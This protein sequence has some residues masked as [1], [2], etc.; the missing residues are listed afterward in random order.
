VRHCSESPQ[1]LSQTAAFAVLIAVAMA[2]VFNLGADIG[3]MGDA[4][5]L[6]VPGKVTVFVVGFGAV[7]LVAILL[8]PYSVESTQTT[9]DPVRRAKTRTS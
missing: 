1:K 9:A 4:L 8:V 2:N 3:A 7:S 5:H 6:L